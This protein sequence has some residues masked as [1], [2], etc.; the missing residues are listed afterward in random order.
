MSDLPRRLTTSEVCSL[1]RYSSVTLWR[2][3]KAGEMP[4]PVDEGRQALFDRDAVLKALGMLHEAPPAFTF[5][6]DAF[7]QAR[8][9]PVRDAAPAGRRNLSRV[10]PGAGEAAALRLA[11]RNAQAKRGLVNASGPGV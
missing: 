9:R 2:R 1:A 4:R 3:I 11:A 8:S 6:P 7:R 10:L 5:D